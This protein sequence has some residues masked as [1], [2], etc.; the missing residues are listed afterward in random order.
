MKLR[1][2]DTVVI[3]SRY[4]KIIQ[5]SDLAWNNT[6]NVNCIKSMVTGWLQ[7]ESI[8]KWTKAI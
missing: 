4:A 8:M 7:N 5:V 6:C 1:K 3:P 2:V